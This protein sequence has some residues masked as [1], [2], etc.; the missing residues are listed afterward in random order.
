MQEI[1]EAKSLTPY[2]LMLALTK[3]S[4]AIKQV[5]SESSN[6]DKAAIIADLQKTYDE[7]KAKLEEITQKEQQEMKK[8]WTLIGDPKDEFVDLGS[9]HI[10][11]PAT[12]K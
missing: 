6:L 1:I 4:T 5:D 12:I 10:H 11:R 2:G 7:I 9:S 8:D 3:L